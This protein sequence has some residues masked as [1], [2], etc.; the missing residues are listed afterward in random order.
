MSPDN[1][2]SKVADRNLIDVAHQYQLAGVHLWPTVCSPDTNER[3]SFLARHGIN[4][5]STD[6]VPDM[7]SASSSTGQSAR[8]SILLLMP[9]A[10]ASKASKIAAMNQTAEVI[11]TVDHYAQVEILQQAA[12]EQR[13]TVRTLVT[14]N[15]GANFFGCRPG[16]DTLQLAKV[17]H[18][19]PNLSFE[20]LTAEVPADRTLND[21]SREDS[22]ISAL[23]DTALKVQQK[24]MECSLV[25][26]RTHA[27]I[28]PSRVPTGWQ[29]SIPL[30]AISR[31]KTESSA[32]KLSVT[33]TQ[34]SQPFMATIVARPSLDAVIIDCGTNVIQHP[35]KIILSTGDQLP[36]K[37]IDDFRCVLD[38]T[39]ANTELS[40]GQQIHFSTDTRKIEH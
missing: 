10:D 30:N 38:M 35:A 16:T 33:K 23:L 14:I 18:Q 13:T 15:A 37:Q 25:H 19:Q 34:T 7:P 28:S 36:V 29:I 8:P 21:I 2:I 6:Q 39:H 11:S 32:T 3:V 27:F 1:S 17:I 22:A 4:Q 9:T 31:T 5:F 20:G 40:I 26:L 24:G 12:S